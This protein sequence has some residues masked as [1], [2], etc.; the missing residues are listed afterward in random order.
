MIRA[1]DLKTY[2]TQLDKDGRIR[3]AEECGTTPG[4]LRNVV[5]G[6]PCGETLAMSIDLFTRG[7]VS[8]EEMRSDLIVLWSHLRTSSPVSKGIGV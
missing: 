5:Y 6:K 7:E 2:W 3:M 4:H 1:M 8:C